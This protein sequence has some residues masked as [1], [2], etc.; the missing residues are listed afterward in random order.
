MGLREQHES[1]RL[2]GCFING[3]L[4]QDGWKPPA[5]HKRSDGFASYGGG[6]N[7]RVGPGWD[8]ARLDGIGECELVIDGVRWV[9]VNGE[10]QP[11]ESVR[12]LAK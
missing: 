10:W 5:H 4:Q 1:A 8:D 7:Q 9:E 3:L 11:E 6:G 12:P 2:H